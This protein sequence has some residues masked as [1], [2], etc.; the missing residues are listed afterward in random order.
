MKICF[1]MTDFHDKDGFEG[2]LLFYKFSGY[3]FCG[4]PFKDR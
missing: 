4:Y 2:R 1:D 3:H